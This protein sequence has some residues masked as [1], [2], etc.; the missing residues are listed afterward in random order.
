MI[1]RK[2]TIQDIE[3]LRPLYTE[4]EIDAVMYQPERF[5][6][7]DGFCEMMKTLECPI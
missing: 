7:R 5:Y 2:A 4:L 1:I 6:E 3:Q